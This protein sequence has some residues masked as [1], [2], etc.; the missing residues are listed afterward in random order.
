[1]D[2]HALLT[3]RKTILDAEATALICG[4]DAAL[5]L[6]HTGSIY[7][8]SD[9]RPALRIFLDTSSS[10]PL[11]YLDPPLSKLAQTSRK[12]FP[13]WIKGH[14]GH[15]GNERADALAKTASVPGDP[16]PGT[17]HSYLALHLTTATSTEWLA[18]FARV[19]HEYTRHP[20]RHTKL[21][22]GLTRLES[23][24]LFRLR[25]NKGWSAGDNIGTRTPPP[26]PC[27][28]RT[29]RDGFHLLSC[30]TSSRLRP[31]DAMSWVHLDRRRD[32]ILKWAA[33]HKFFGI[34]LRTS[35]VKWIRLSRPGNISPAA[36]PTCPLCT[37]VFSNKSHLT[38]HMKNPHF[39]TLCYRPPAK[40][41][42]LYSPFQQ[43][44]RA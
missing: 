22:R 44:N 20:T 21:H 38:R 1:M 33:Y 3:P 27:D 10:G 29:P 13:A 8:L 26:C 19:A 11:S 42:P 18:W 15:P 28:N 17:T 4:L 36:T 25:S 9:C 24:V 30:P 34:S 41:L 12:I 35:P 23:S 16:F 31:P 39:D 40:L 43:Q 32:S 37:R 5:A 14:A 6:P 7:L 2:Y